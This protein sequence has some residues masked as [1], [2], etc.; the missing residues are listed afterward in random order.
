MGDAFG[1]M[2]GVGMKS[3]L[4]VRAKMLGGQNEIEIV[5]LFSAGFVPK[6]RRKSFIS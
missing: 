4:R 6:E 1:V 2:A 5:L 3:A